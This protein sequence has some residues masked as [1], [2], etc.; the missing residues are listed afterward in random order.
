MLIS[1]PKTQEKPFHPAHNF[2]RSRFLLACLLITASFFATGCNFPVRHVPKLA[3]GQLSGMCYRAYN[4]NVA[5]DISYLPH[6][7]KSQR[8]DIYMT[9]EPGLSPVFV[10]IHGGSWITGSRTQYGMLGRVLS[11]QGI[12]TVTV[13]YRLNPEVTYPAFMKDCDAALSWVIE[14]IQNYGGDP[15]RVFLAGHSAGA[16]IAALMLVHDQ[17]RQAGAFDTQSLA[18]AVLMS[19]AYE[20][21]EDIGVDDELVRRVMNTPENYLDAQPIRHTRGDVPPILII[22]GT[23]DK[24]TGKTQASKFAQ[25]MKDKGADIHYA[26]IPK[27]DHLTVLIDMLPGE[28]GETYKRIVEFL[29]ERSDSGNN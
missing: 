4:E 28:K 2:P 14:H 12:V 20:F 24:V 3:S 1:L 18:G 8:L 21:G 9:K 16:H 25:A 11:E 26:T 17:F 10:F 29:Q 6:A 7:T 19:G 13:D 27:G 5:R 15:Q 22:Q 23:E